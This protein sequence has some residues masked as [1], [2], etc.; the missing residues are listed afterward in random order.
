MRKPKMSLIQLSSI[1]EYVPDTGEFKW[2]VERKRGI[3]PG[4]IAGS[5]MKA[6]YRTIRIDGVE[7]YA[8][9]LAWLF[10]F[11]EWPEFRLDHKNGHGDDNAIKNLR[12]ATQS[13]NSANRRRASNN[14]TGFKGVGKRKGRFEARIGFEG[15]LRVIGRY[16]TA[17]QA[18][19]AYCTE[20]ERLFGEF[21]R[22]A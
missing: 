7:F 1:L 17:E 5:L 22:A 18:H 16:E 14:S 20:A 9:R 4:D 15:K 11:A 12:R 21:A 6:G 3:K 2:K 8:H 13:Q 10:V 19:S